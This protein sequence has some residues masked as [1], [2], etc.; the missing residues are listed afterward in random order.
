MSDRQVRDA[1]MGSDTPSVD[2][3]TQIGTAATR[4]GTIADEMAKAKTEDTARFGELR[5]EQKRLASDLDALK[6]RK[7]ADD[8][9]AEH[10]ETVKAAQEWR[11]YASTIRTPSKAAILGF[12]GG[13]QDSTYRSGMFLGAILGVNDRDYDVQKAAKATL[14]HLGAR[15]SD[16]PSESKATLGDTAAAGGWVVPNAIVDALV[17]PG[18]YSHPY[19]D[20]CTVVSGVTSAQVDIPFRS[21]APARAVVAPFGTLKENVDLAYNGYTATMYTIARIHDIGK[22]FARQSQGAAE[23]D[24]LQELAH[25]FALGE[26]YYILQGTGSSQPYGLQ[27]AITNAPATFTSSFSAA[28]TLAGSMANA[29]ATAAGAVAGRNRTPTGAVMSASSYWAMLAQ[30]T[31]NAGFWFAGSRQGGTPEGIRP[32][33]LISPFGIPVY[34]DAS[35]LAG[36]DDLIVGDWAALKLYFGESYRVDSSDVAGTRWDYNLI[37]FR[38]EEEMGLDARPA[39]YAGAFQF[40]AD[41]VP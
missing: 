5:D 38:G 15:W 27:T 37:G 22:Q 31:D 14:E 9:E 1:I 23:Q 29:I 28:A 2:L 40:I 21:A 25:A 4:L 7:D 36:S 32:N 30:G 35:S 33:T 10:A 17:K 8:R 12:G 39:V 41:I 16:V 13:S 18:V 20:L 6:A 11:Q 34:P 19:R 24:V 3:A 26:A